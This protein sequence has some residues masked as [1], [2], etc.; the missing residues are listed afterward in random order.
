[1]ISESYKVQS[2]LFNLDSQFT[3]LDNV[4][5]K[6]LPAVITNTN[7]ELIE[8]CKSLV[9]S[10]NELLVGENPTSL[11]PLA[12]QSLTDA[13]CK[14]LED[15]GLNRYCAQSEE[16]TDALLSDILT[17]IDELQ[18]TA[19]PLI[20]DL[21]KKLEG[22]ALNQIKQALEKRKN[23]RKQTKPISLTNAQ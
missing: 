20:T 22:E 15:T 19:S 9:N 12:P 13:I 11:I 16:V 14:V 3:F 21:I 17:V 4:P 10:R 23:K 7:G 2:P 6:F 8:R 1:M 18:S 5:E